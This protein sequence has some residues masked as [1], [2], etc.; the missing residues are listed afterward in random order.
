MDDMTDGTPDAPDK[1]LKPTPE[2]GDNYVNADI[3]LPRCVTISRGQVIE[4]KCDADGNPVERSNDN[5]ILDSRH[6]LVQ[7]EYGEVTEF[8]SHVIYE[9][10]YAMRDP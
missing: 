9:Y 6:Y 5:P 3:M 2:S 8:S 4:R 7:I 1:Y 10:I